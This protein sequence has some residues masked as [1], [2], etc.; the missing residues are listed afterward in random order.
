[1]NMDI[2]IDL[3]LSLVIVGMLVLTVVI[4]NKNARQHGQANP[5]GTAA[6]QADVSSLKNKM[7]RMETDIKNIRRDIDHAP[8]QADFARLEER[9]EGVK[10]VVEAKFDAMSDTITSVGQATVRMNQYLL[11]QAGGEEVVQMVGVVKK[12]PARPRRKV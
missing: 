10:E 1:M 4:S 12:R 7:G 11:D 6:L 2:D 5:V 9:I 8:S 3:I